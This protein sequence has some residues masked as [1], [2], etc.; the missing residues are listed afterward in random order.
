MLGV[1]MHTTIKTLFLKGYNKSQIAVMLN[2]DRKT[3]RNILKQFEEKGSVE[4]KARTSILDPYKE[5]IQILV[6]KDLSSKRIFQDITKEGFDGGY[7]SVKKY[8]YRIKKKAPIPFMVLN[9]F[10][11]EEAQVDFGYIGTIKLPDG[12][13]KK[14][15]IFVMELSYSRYMYVQIVFDQTV[16]TFIECHKKSFKYFGGVPKNVKVDNLKA[17]VLEADF[18]E[19][20]FQRNYADFANF[21]GFLAEPC[22]VY[23]PTD[24]GKVESNVK[25]V[26]NNCF[27]GRDFKDITEARSFLSEWLETIANIRIHGTTKEIPKNIFLSIEKKKLLKLPEEEYFLSDVK[28]ATVYPNCHVAYK[29]NYYSAPYEYI[30]E[31]VQLLIQD[32]ILKIY[33][34][35]KEIALHS[36]VKDM[37]GKYQTDKNHYPDKKTITTEEIKSRLREEMSQGYSVLFTTI[38]AMLEDLY[39][40]RADNSFNQKMKNYVNPDLL[41]LD[42]LG[43]KKLNQNSVDDFYEVISRRYESGSVIITSNKVFDE[44]GHIFYDPVLATAI[45][46]KFIHHCNFILI[47]GESYRMKEQEAK[48]KKS[49][50]ENQ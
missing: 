20:V 28:D 10:P 4:R 12:K 19:P 14:A 6:S 35:D 16:K 15:W 27:K 33:H 24:K 11:G 37:K 9:S 39:I 49:T 44:W 42:E 46:D 22:R 36:L 41:I 40:S 43:I 45:L 7:D 38:S 1:E 25:Y 32:N 13:R 18:C 2:V 23:T 34:K 3:V 30:G 29:N 50:E 8:V 17:A 47:D 48:I 31:K 5:T 26:K 21:Y